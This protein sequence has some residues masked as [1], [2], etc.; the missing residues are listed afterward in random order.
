MIVASTTVTEK[1]DTG[2]YQVQLGTLPRAFSSSPCLSFRTLN[3]TSNLVNGMPFWSL[4]SKSFSANSATPLST[5]SVI[6]KRSVVNCGPTPSRS[7]QKLWYMSVKEALISR[8]SAFTKSGKSEA[9]FIFLEPCPCPSKR[10]KVR[11][12]PALCVKPSQSLAA[13]T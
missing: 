13:S 3:T 12:G 6:S 1:Q 4:A 11:L 8:T 2:R 10:T 9:P 7:F 5:S